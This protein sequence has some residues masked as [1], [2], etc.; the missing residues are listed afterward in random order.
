MIVT[1]KY[2]KTIGME[3]PKDDSSNRSYR[4]N[5]KVPFASFSFSPGN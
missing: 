2:V 3:Y 4:I 1:R 5:T